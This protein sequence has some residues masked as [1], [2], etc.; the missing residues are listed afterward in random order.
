MYLYPTPIEFTLINLF[1]EGYL[2]MHSFT[3]IPLHPLYTY[4]YLKPFPP[5]I[6]LYPF[7]ISR[8][9][10]T[11]NIHQIWDWNYL[12]FYTIYLAVHI[13]HPEENRIKSICTPTS[14][15][16]KSITVK[17]LL[18][19]LGISKMEQVVCV[20]HYLHKKVFACGDFS[21]D[22]EIRYIYKY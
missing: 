3:I 11:H 21:S 7:K 10:L 1:S 16:N 17:V 2:W 22:Q 15:P 14:R 12:I 20:R 18:L 9:I 5:S 4:Y 6:R 8:I 19:K 13:A